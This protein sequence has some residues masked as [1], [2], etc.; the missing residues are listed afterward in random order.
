M[1]SNSNSSSL[2]RLA[3]LPFT[4]QVYLLHFR[5]VIEQITNNADEIDTELICQEPF[6]YFTI[7]SIDPDKAE[8]KIGSLAIFFFTRQARAVCTSSLSSANCNSLY[9]IQAYIQK[10][11]IFDVVS[12]STSSQAL[13]FTATPKN[14]L[15]DHLSHLSTRVH[16]RPAAR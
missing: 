11:G 12:L 2:V 4:H 5:D 8:I 9:L 7:L 10:N 15:V 3:T 6:T 13:S 1:N 16:G 14:R